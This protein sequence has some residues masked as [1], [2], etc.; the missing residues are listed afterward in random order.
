MVYNLFIGLLASHGANILLTSNY[1]LERGAPSN[2]QDIIK[3][4]SEDNCIIKRNPAK[5]IDVFIELVI[6]K[7][8][9]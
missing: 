6:C 9:Y 5:K 3:D 8:L 2:I 1:T 7:F 4:M